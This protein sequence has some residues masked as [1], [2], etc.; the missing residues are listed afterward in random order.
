MAKRRLGQLTLDSTIET[1]RNLPLD[2]RQ[3][4]RTKEE[5]LDPESFVGVAYKGMLVACRD[6]EK[7]Y[8][9]L[10]KDN[11]TLEESWKEI[12]SVGGEVDLTLYTKYSDFEFATEADIDEI[13][14]S[15]TQEN[16]IENPT[17]NLTE[18]P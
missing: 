18:N 16:P 12:G 8:M 17:E 14:Y 4:V 3:L 11:P 6:D 1:T 5:L 2:A 15:V 10:D 7:L 9:L 13:F